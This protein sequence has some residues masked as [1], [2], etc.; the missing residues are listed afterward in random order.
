MEEELLRKNLD[1]HFKAIELCM[2]NRLRMPA[3]ILIYSAIDFLAWLDRPE[4][5]EDVDKQQFIEWANRYLVTAGFSQCSAVDL[6]SARCAH[7]HGNNFE[8]SMTR[9]GKASPVIYAWGTA[10]PGPL[11]AATKLIQKPEVRVVHIETL[12]AAV[13]A[14]SDAFLQSAKADKSKWTLIIS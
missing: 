2:A 6:Y 3:L 13:I 10:T 8:S 11:L 4:G 5:K 9:K 1:N 12:M 14:G 7:L